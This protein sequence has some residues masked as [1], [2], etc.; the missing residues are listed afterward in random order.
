MEGLHAPCRDG[1]VLPAADETDGPRCLSSSERACF[2][3]L[4]REH[5]DAV[6]AALRARLPNEDDVADLMQE[7]YLRMLRYRNCGPDSL[8]YL[9]FRIA[10][11]LAVTHLRQAGVRHLV[12][13]DEHELASD[14]LPF[15]Q[16]L[17]R[18]EE[19][20]Q[21]AMAIQ[22]LPP[23][24]RQMYVMSRLHGLRQREIAQHCGVSTRMVELHIAR[25]QATIRERC[26]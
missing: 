26:T 14:E 17:V 2:D 11:N 22:A 1:D 9:L 5:R 15:D 12:S 3:A 19:M 7:A 25:A 23:R 18:E 24:C 8:R 6:A 10:L 16:A 13:L 4:Y 21:V 20:A